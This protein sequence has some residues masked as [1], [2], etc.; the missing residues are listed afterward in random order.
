MEEIICKGEGDTEFWEAH[1]LNLDWTPDAPEV[2]VKADPQD[3][4]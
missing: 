3:T 1:L 2:N 4:Y